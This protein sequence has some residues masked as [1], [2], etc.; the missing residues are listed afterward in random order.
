MV[1]LV[2]QRTCSIGIVVTTR[3]RSLGQGYIF[4]GVCHSVNRG[5][6]C[7]GDPPLCQGDPPAKETL[8]S[9]ETPH[10]GDPPLPRRPPCQG[11]PHQGDPLPGRPPPKGDPP[12]PRRT[13]LPGRPPPGRPPA[14][15]IPLGDP[16]PGRPLHQGDP[17]AKET[18]L[19]GDQVQAH[20][21]GGN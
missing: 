18:P 5:G 13:P 6:V 1:C 19:Q 3:K 4:T 7:Q 21:Q 2:L 17:P 15:E 20:N 10:Q 9:R 14:R 12:L 8:P 16:L 11:D